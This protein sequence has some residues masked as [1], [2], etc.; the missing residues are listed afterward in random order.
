M[1]LGEI[2]DNAVN[3]AVGVPYNKQAKTAAITPDEH[4]RMEF[5][6]D[7]QEAYANC[8][9][10]VGSG[11]YGSARQT[12]SG[13]IIK[14][15]EIK[16][17]YGMWLAFCMWAYHRGSGN[18]QLPK[19]FAVS[20]PDSED[21][22]SYGYALMEKLSKYND[23]YASDKDREAE[24]FEFRNGLGNVGAAAAYGN[25]IGGITKTPIE[26]LFAEFCVLAKNAN[27]QIG[28]DAHMGNLLFRNMNTDKEVA[29]LT[30]PAVLSH[31]TFNQ[32]LRFMRDMLNMVS[33]YKPAMWSEMRSRKIVEATVQ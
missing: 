14:Q 17:A 27:M 26:R 1:N 13:F 12:A 2:S 32:A 15:F 22:S 16:D 24:T 11:M 30:D 20:L 18:A 28:V 9:R 33:H 31:G 5:L 19:V 29:V 10:A 25:P 3:H 8:T 23:L 4:E 7:P 21:T 6:K